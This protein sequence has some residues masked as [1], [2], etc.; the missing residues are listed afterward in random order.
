VTVPYSYELGELG[1]YYRQYEELM[2]AWSAALP[3]DTI[4]TIDYETLVNDFGDEARRIVGY[5]GLEWDDACLAFHKVRRPVRTASVAQ[6]RQP[7]FS[8]SLRKWRP[9]DQILQPL[10]EGLWRA[11]LQS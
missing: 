3:G 7:L 6:V 5:C 11:G 2:A 9:S 1:R 10:L 8:T 4:L